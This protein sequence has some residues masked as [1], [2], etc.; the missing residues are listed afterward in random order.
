MR[1]FLTELLEGLRIA[2]SAL[3]AHPLRAVLTT[4]GI[5]V[6]VLAV[7]SMGI[8]ING[9]ERSFERTLSSLGASTLRV[10]RQPAVRGPGYDWW[11][12]ADRPPIRERVYHALRERAER[13]TAVAPVVTTRRTASHRGRSARDV[14]VQGTTLDFERIRAPQLD[15]GRFFSP[16]ESRGGRPVAVVSAGLAEV[17]FPAGVALRRTVE[18]DGRPYEVVGVLESTR[19]GERRMI[20]PYG[21]FRR[22]FGVPES[23]VVEVSAGAPGR[24]ERVEGEVIQIVR[25]VRGVGPTARNNFAV[26][27]QEQLREQLAPVKATIYGVGLF[28]TALALLV[29]GIGVM[30]IMFVSVR[31]RTREIGIRKA[32]GARRRA[33][34]L[35]FLTEAVLICLVGGAIGLVGALGVERLVATVLPGVLTAGHVLAALAGCTAVGLL[36]GLGPAWAAATA[37]PVEA[38]RHE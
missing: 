23:L 32:V 1:R 38:I 37:D 10:Q 31:E 29:G 28:L 12:Y 22:G 19:R 21:A 3:W 18:V 30:N 8:V 7:T 15:R 13:A 16:M 11:K 26:V 35:Q 24:V 5:V 34:L 36:F 20:V 6:G 33:L 2:G 4:P 17:L 14:V 25:R 27:K 9:L